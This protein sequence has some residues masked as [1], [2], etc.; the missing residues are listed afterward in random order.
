M[1]WKKDRVANIF[2]ELNMKHNMNLDKVDTVNEWNLFIFFNVSLTYSKI[3]HI[4]VM[5]DDVLGTNQEKL[6][7]ILW[8]LSLRYFF[9]AFYYI[10]LIWVNYI[11]L[12][13]G[14]TKLHK[15]FFNHQINLITYEIM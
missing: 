14:L 13:W 6:F 8:V 3:S 1:G 12:L 4:D 10:F 2:V 5:I 9:H 15:F 7:N 11:S